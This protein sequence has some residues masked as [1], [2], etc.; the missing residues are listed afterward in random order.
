MRRLLTFLVAATPALAADLT[1]LEGKKLTGEVVAVDGND[2]TFKSAGGEEKFLVT[3]IGDV[4]FG[5]VVKTPDLN[6]KHVTVELVDGSLFRCSEI[7]VKGK[8]LEMRL[9]GAAPRTLTAVMRDGDAGAVYAVNREAGNAKLEQDFRAIVRDRSRFDIWVTKVGEAAAE[10][11]ESV[12][13]TFGEGDEKTIKFLISAKGSAEQ[14]ILM[15][16]VAGF[17]LRHKPGAAPPPAVCKVIDTDGNEMVASAVGRK[18]GGFAITL[19][20]GMK[21]DLA[22]TQ[23]AKLDFAAGSIKYLSDL[24][25]STVDES[26]TDPEHYQRDKNLDKQPIRIALDPAKGPDT[27]P[28]GLTLKARTALTYD[29]NGAYKTFRAVVGV[30]ADQQNT[31]D[32]SVKVTVDNGSAVIWSGVIKRGQKAVDLNLNVTD[33]AKLKIVVESEGTATDLGNQVSF[34]NARVVK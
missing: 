30:D 20:S 11:L 16:R 4:T 5:N 10:R 26:G 19:V 34:G 33:V 1:T 15:T 9:L 32:S 2:L 24:D 8:M 13:G 22:D 12:P 17:I 28:K 31:A 6:R 29:L 25:P 27:F 18:A 3:T 21:L 14:S 23:V 7:V